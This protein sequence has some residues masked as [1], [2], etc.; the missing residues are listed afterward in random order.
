MTAQ[1][2]QFSQLQQM[3]KLNASFGKMLESV[4]RS[5][6]S[7]LIGKEVS[8]RT[9]AADGSNEIGTG[10]VEQVTIGDEGQIILTVDDQ[11]VDLANVL[12]IR[13]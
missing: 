12:V 3:E 9:A 2:A 8:F 5:Y 4:Q 11:R 10:D 1:L 7:S 13:D 6:A